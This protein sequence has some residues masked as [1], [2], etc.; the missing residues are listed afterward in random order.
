ME[1][2]AELEREWHLGLPAPSL[3]SVSVSFGINL[4]FC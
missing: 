1:G 4:D 3:L 2:A